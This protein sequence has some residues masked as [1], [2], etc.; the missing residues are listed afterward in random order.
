MTEE[1]KWKL[2]EKVI[3]ILEKSL[4]PESKVEH[5]INL[6]VLSSPSNRI[7]QCD[8]VITNGSA[9]RP[10]I[11]IVEVQDRNSKP[12]IGNFSDWCT[13]KEEVGAQ[14]LIC[15]SKIGFPSSIIEKAK[16]MG[17]TVILM[18]LEELKNNSWPI[19]FL[20]NSIYTNRRNLKSIENAKMDFKSNEETLADVEV[21]LDKKMF[22]VKGKRFSSKELI[23]NYLNLE[24][25]KNGLFPEG[26]QK[27][28]ITY[29]LA[30]EKIYW[31]KEDKQ[32]EI[33]KV[34]LIAG[35]EFSKHKFPLKGRVYKQLEQESN[36]AWIMEAKIELNN[37]EREIKIVLAPNNGFYNITFWNL[38]INQ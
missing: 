12:S 31:I 9:Q 34:K 3:K 22:E 21:I 35:V 28:E 20:E 32:F 4:S 29:P 24:E 36:S 10:T 14:H 7:R 27:I 15:V 6:P 30:D 17:P 18:T 33:I 1:P 8:V 23:F 19:K 26:F 11:S 2:V 38:P 25:F 13:K 37:T 16:L 5:N